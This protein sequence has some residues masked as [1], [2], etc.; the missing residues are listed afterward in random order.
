[1]HEIAYNCQLIDFAGLSL[2][3]I[4]YNQDKEKPSRKSQKRDQQHILK[5][6]KAS[7]FWILLNSTES[8]DLNS[9]KLEEIEKKSGH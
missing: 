5:I 6:L 4:P 2:S 9:A 7:K 1:M 8:L 3:E